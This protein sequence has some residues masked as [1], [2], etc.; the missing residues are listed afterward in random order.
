MGEEKA[1]TDAELASNRTTMRPDSVAK[2]DV[3]NNNHLWC[4]MLTVCVLEEAVL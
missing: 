2:A 4:I 1:P 3:D